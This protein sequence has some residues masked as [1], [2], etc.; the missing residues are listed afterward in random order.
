MT[1]QVQT[2]GQ[3]AYEAYIAA[4]GWT[5]A[6]RWQDADEAYRAAW[7]AAAQA[8]PEPLRDGIRELLADIQASADAT[9]P[10][11]KTQTEDEVAA[12]L[13]Q[14]LEEA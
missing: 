6:V 1:G 7:E 13:R 12:Q 4:L 10:S 3:A 11:K 9:R 14:L 8:A 2:P 5:T